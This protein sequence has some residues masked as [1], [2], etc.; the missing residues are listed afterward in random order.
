M[1]KLALIIGGSRGIGRAISLRLARSGFDIWLTYKGNHEAAQ[2][3]KAEIEKLGKTCET[4]PFDVASYEETERALSPRLEQRAPDALVY[5]AGIARDNLLMWMSKREWDEVLTTNL[6]GFFNVTR[7]VLFPMLKA[8]KGRIV[9]VSSASG[10]I[11]QAGQVNYSASKAGLIG[12]AKAL[13]REVGKK[14]IIVNVVAPGFIETEMTEKI[15]KEQVLPLVPLN[16]LGRPEDVAAVVDFLCSEEHLY[17]HGQV[18]GID[19]GLAIT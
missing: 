7:A 15:P 6:D 17:V 12:A 8:K 10:R 19:G 18:I 5:S 16:R 13:A 4:I 3:V 11:G 1:N 9:V 14:N 2:A